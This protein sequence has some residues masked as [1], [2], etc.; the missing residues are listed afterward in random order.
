VRIP[1]FLQVRSLTLSILR[2]FAVLNE[3]TQPKFVELYDKFLEIENCSLLDPKFCPLVKSVLIE[4]KV[5]MASENAAEDIQKV[6][7]RRQLLFYLYAF[8]FLTN[9]GF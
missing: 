4:C 8:Y 1:I 7:T 9:I 2:N 6:Q 5:L 3:N